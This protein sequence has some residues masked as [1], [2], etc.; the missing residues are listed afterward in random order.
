MATPVAARTVTRTG[1]GSVGRWL[2]ERS[3]RRRWHGP[4][5]ALRYRDGVETLIGLPPA[6]ATI[7]IHDRSALWELLRD[8]SRGFGRAYVDGRLDVEG[9]LQAL[10]QAAFTGL[11]WAGIKPPGRLSQLLHWLATPR[12][13]PTQ[14]E[15]N[16]WFHYDAGNRFFRLWLDPSMTYSCAYFRRDGDTLEAAQRQKLEI[17]CRKLELDKGQ[18][19]LDIGCGWGALVFHAIQRYGVRAVG[20]TPSRQQA[21]YVAQEAARRRLS[22]RLC[23]EVVDWRKIRGSFDR[24]VSVGMYEHVGRPQGRE[25]FQRWSRLLRPDGISVLHTMGAMNTVQPDAW[26]QESIFP[27]GYIP[28]L[29]ELAQHAAE[30]EMVVAD[31]ENLWRHYAMTTAAWVRNF[32]A[33]RDEILAISGNDDRFVRHWWLA[34]NAFQAA[35]VAGRLLLFQLVLTP[36]K[37]AAQPLTRE[38][39]VA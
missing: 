5:I 16:A 10:L 30:A 27:G 28:S 3:L 4:G 19:L 14:A 18:T 26:S 24:I 11:G 33:V 15:A 32:Q 13:W 1:G 34:L 38:A 21:E 12:T 17:L 25:F 35:F 39:W 2:L 23:L 8:A 29:A 9:D 31:V 22:D 7:R 20:V 6:T 37:R 36:G